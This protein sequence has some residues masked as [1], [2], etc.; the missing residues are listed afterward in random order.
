MMPVPS[1]RLV[2][3]FAALAVASGVLLIFPEAWP[4]LVAANLTVVLVAA[5]D[6]AVTPRPGVLR[7]ARLAPDRMQVLHE[8]RIV[9]RVENAAG[10]RLHVRMRDAAPAAFGGADVE[11][12]GPVPARGETRWEYTLTPR[13]R[14]R[15]NVPRQPG[16]ERRPAPR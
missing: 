4:L 14:A 5:V 9:I 8:Q 2:V 11:R 6:L 7:A 13:S 1:S 12:D 15:A 10:V 16:R 3:T